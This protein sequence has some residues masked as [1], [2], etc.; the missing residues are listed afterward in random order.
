MAQRVQPVAPPVAPVAPAPDTWTGQ[1][2]GNLGPGGREALAD[3][4]HADLAGGL[5]LPEEISP[6]QAAAVG[7]A[8]G[9]GARAVGQFAKEQFYDPVR[10]WASPLAGPPPGMTPEQAAAASRRAA[11]EGAFSMVGGVKVPGRGLALQEQALRELGQLR[12]SVAQAGRPAM[13]TAQELE[14]LRSRGMAPPAA[15]GPQHPSNLPPVSTTRVARTP[16][17]AKLAG[18]LGDLDPGVQRRAMMQQAQ[19]VVANPAGRSPEEIRWAYGLLESPAS[20]GPQAGARVTAKFAGGEV[21]HL[22]DGG[23]AGPASTWD[24]SPSAPPPPPEASWSPETGPIPAPQG[25]GAGATAPGGFLAPFGT[26]ITEGIPAMVGAEP[27]QAAPLQAVPS[28]APARRPAPAAPPPGAQLPG[29]A[30]S[31]MDPFAQVMRAMQPPAGAVQ[32]LARAQRE[33]YTQEAGAARAQG[34]WV[35][36]QQ[37]WYKDAWSKIDA[38]REATVSDYM[39]SHIDPGHVFRD[40]SVPQKALAVVGMLFSGIGSGITGQP[41]LAAQ[42]IQR[43]IEMDVQAQ[44]QEMDKKK[45]L[46]GMNMERYGNL[47]AAM[48]ASALQQSA[49]YEAKIRELAATSNAAQAGPRAQMAI[50]QLRQPLIPIMMQMAQFKG[51]QNMIRSGGHVVGDMPA[52]WSWDQYMA[53]AMPGPAGRT[54]FARSPEDRKAAVEGLQKWDAYGAQLED[55]A[56]SRSSLAAVPLTDAQH[57]YDQ[58]REALILSLGQ[59]MGVGRGEAFKLI[60]KMAPGNVQQLMHP[61]SL[62]PLRELGANGRWS[63]WETHGS[64]HRPRL[65]AYG[66]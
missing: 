8:A 20:A 17:P 10:L 37:R 18:D 1:L 3:P 9:A 28:H 40:K 48:Q 6:E 44:A 5:G 56:N 46:V 4:T 54:T 35:Q 62:Q 55:L 11:V 65:P 66:Q 61:N 2:L 34:A 29:A 33:Q 57:E 32:D 39:N 31:P 23:E 7:Q 47:N 25:V 16:P 59:A 12:A 60:E 64:L 22:A 14:W 19:A 43:Q 13:S 24:W 30:G 58:R 36:E 49:Y 51:L 42:M 53:T 50:Y 41:N 15:L 38:D 63:I 26:A 52:P 21:Q 27:P 45:N